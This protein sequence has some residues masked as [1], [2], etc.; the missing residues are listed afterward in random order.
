VVKL[1]TDPGGPGY[2]LLRIDSRLT[3]ALEKTDLVG[4]QTKNGS[5]IQVSGNVNGKKLLLFKAR[6]YFS[7][8]GNVVRTIIEG[9][10]LLDQLAVVTPDQ[11]TVQDQPTA[12]PVKEEEKLG[13]KAALGRDRQK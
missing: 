3:D 9:G 1:I 8:A 7:P 4:E 2:S 13:T 10:P 11:P 6:S 12:A 5:G